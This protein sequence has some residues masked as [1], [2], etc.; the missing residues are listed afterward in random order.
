MSA[1][2]TFDAPADIAELLARSARPLLLATDVDGTLAP[3]APRPEHARLAPGALDALRA[4]AAIPSIDIAVVSGRS[5]VEL[6]DQFGLDGI[7]HLVGSH[8]AESTVDVPLDQQEQRL[9]D[10]VADGLGG[11]SRA[12]PGATLEA[13]PMAIAL[14]VRGATPEDA[15]HALSTARAVFGM[16]RRVEVHEGHQVYEIA[17]R[18]STKASALV[19]LRDALAPATVAFLGD[20]RSDETAFVDLGATDLGVKVGVGPTAARWRLAAPADVVEV[21]RRLAELAR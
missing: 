6:R 16:D 3:I 15:R 7:G 10:E 2:D 17:V 18:H 13:K 19:D 12:T 14:H 21:F 4:L 20:D 11:I 1:A 5:L 9:L 8:G